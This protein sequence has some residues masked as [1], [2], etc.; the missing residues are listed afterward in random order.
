MTLKSRL[1]GLS[2]LLIAL[3]VVVQWQAL[4][5]PLFL[6]LRGLTMPL[7]SGLWSNL[8]VL[9]DALI[10]PLF[11][12]PFVKKCPRLPLMGLM[13]ALIATV[14]THGIKPI[15]DVPRPPAVLDLV[16]IG[17]V[18]QAGS[19]PSG[20]TL[21]AFT[22][23]GLLVLSGAL[24]RRW[25]VFGAGVLAA[26]VGISRIAVGVHWP[27]DILM[28]AGLGVLAALLSQALLSRAAFHNVP[29]IVSRMI[30]CVIGLIAVFNLWSHHTGYP[31]ALILQKLVAVASLV[32][33]IRGVWGKSAD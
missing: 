24:D 17:P 19:L 1:F 27:A 13:G 32:F 14:E 16:V 18:W 30:L 26:L 4:N 28:G 31:E 3:A 23:W 29:D 33:L 22:V 10:A 8:T 11:L 6:W 21:S 5:I 20:H 25:Q 2:L 12:I 9:G 7:G 15:F